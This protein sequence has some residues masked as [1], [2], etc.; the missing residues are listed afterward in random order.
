MQTPFTGAMAE[1]TAMTRAGRLAEATALIQ[2]AL[3]AGAPET[4]PVPESRIPGPKAG[5]KADRSLRTG[6]RATLR[7]LAERA[8]AIDVEDPALDPAL[9]PGAQ[10]DTF[11]YV[12]P[13]GARDYRLYVPA[14]RPEGPLP[15]VVM[16]HGCTQTPTDFARGTRMNPLAEEFGVLIAYPAQPGSANPNR[17]WNWFRPGDQR[18]DTGEP[19][20]IAGIV[21]KVI[22]DHGADPAR[23]Y[24]AGLSAGGAAAAVLGAEYPDIFAAVGVHS[25]LPVGA[26]RDL[27]SALGAMR[28]GPAV[29]GSPQPTPAIV[30]HGDADTV[31]HPRNGAA[32]ALQTTSSQAGLTATARHDTAGGRGFTRTEHADGTGRI[33]VEHWTLHGAGHAWSGGDAAGSHTDA[34]GPDA[35]REMLRFFL[36][37]GG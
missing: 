6:L 17:C 30:F 33:L 21:G 13:D 14:N 28:S 22:A 27:P 19:A 24:V 29:S 8:R 16:L 4:P 5:P 9:P 37:H 20:L 35:S 25:G 10:F 7:R 15:L 1:A 3:R 23:V 11:S 2:S 12:G 18:R 36:T 26:A 32:V 31:V 34:A